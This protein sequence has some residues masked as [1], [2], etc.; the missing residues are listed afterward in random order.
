M[1]IDQKLK[2]VCVLEVQDRTT[3]MTQDTPMNTQKATA[4]IRS[5]GVHSSFI[6]SRLLASYVR[7]RFS[8]AFIPSNSTFAW[9]ALRLAP[10]IF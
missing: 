7:V 10:T 5:T 8:C 2:K 6:S 4:T 1:T 9:L 3:A